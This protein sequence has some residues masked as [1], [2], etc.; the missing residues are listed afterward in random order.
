MGL[1]RFGGPAGASAG[2]GEESEGLFVGD[3]LGIEEV[4]GGVEKGEVIL[5]GAGEIMG[6]G[7]DQ[8]AESAAMEIEGGIEV[9]GGHAFAG[10]VGGLGGVGGGLEAGLGEFGEEAAVVVFEPGGESGFVEGAE[11]VHEVGAGVHVDGEVGTFGGTEVEQGA[12]FGL[13]FAEEVVVLDI[14]A[15]VVGVTAG[16][17]DGGEIEG[18]ILFTLGPAD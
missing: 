8:Y 5:L 2:I 18:D 14:D 3:Q 17:L 15:G 7:F 12:C 11:G 10:R 16:E 6:G 1:F 13:G 4:I 9:E